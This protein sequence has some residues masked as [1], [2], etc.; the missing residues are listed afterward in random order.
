LIWFAL[1]CAPSPKSVAP[2]LTPIFCK[3]IFC[4]SLLS[5][6]AAQVQAAIV[7]PVGDFLP[8]YTAAF[9]KNADLDAVSADV[10]Y[11]SSAHTFTL[12]GTMNGVVGVAT[13]SA[14]YV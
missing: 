9:P 12:T 6:T 1:H 5:F 11:N 3:R 7:D 2:A 13:P 4:L 10:I 14:A 8:S